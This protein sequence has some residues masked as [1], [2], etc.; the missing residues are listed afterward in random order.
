[1]CIP[2]IMLAQ[3]AKDKEEIVKANTTKKEFLH[4]DAGLEEFFN[5]AYGYAIFP[6]I[7][8]GA[9]VVGGAHGSGTVFKEGVPTGTSTMSQVSIGFQ[10]G[11]QAYME[12]VFLKDKRAYDNFVEGKF[13][14]AAQ[15]SAVAVTAGASLDAQYNDGVAI[16]TLAKGGL[17][18]EASVGGQKFDFKKYEE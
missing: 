11:G 17:M 6:T 8:K 13:K 3:T 16:F 10:F 1:M 7:G 15:V 12:V 5:T 14:L 9:A 2:G 4:Q 18:Y